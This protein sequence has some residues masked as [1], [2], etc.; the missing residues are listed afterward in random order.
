VSGV[1][2]GFWVGMAQAEAHIHFTFFD[3]ISCVEEFFMLIFSGW[4]GFCEN[5]RRSDC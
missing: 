3:L 1:G 4:F 2:A 5:F